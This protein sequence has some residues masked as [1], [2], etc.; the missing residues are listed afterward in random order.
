M[1]YDTS[2]GLSTNDS[3][4]LS[5]KRRRSCSPDLE[6]SM[7]S[8]HKYL[9]IMTNTRKQKL[10]LFSAPVIS[11]WESRHM[12]QELYNARTEITSLQERNN[13]LFNLKRESDIL[14]EKEK[15]AL[16]HTIT[17]SKLTVCKIASYHISI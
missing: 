2:M 3:L 10:F 8:K 17:K 12:K 13:T 7:L 5:N 4:L 11:P 16:E 6:E 1:Q 9:N 14:F 15:T